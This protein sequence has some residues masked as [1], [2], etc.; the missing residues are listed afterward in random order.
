MGRSGFGVGRG[1]SLVL[2][3]LCSA[4][5]SIAG[6]SDGG[7]D[8]MGGAGGVAGLGGTGAVGGSAGASGIGGGG[9]GGAAGMVGGVGG[10]IGGVGGGGV[11]G[12]G[13]GGM[14]G[15]VGG[16]GVGGG[17]VG[18]MMAGTGGMGGTGGAI[19]RGEAP[20]MDSA[21]A[22]GPYT[23]DSY[24]SGFRAPMNFAG[25]TIWHPTGA[26]APFGA[27]AICPGFLSPESSIAEWG[28]FLAS[29]GIV[30]MTIETTTT[31]DQVA[32]RAPALMDALAIIK[33]ENSRSG[34][35]L[36]G[37]IDVD[38]L[39]LMGWSMGGGATW[40]NISE[41]PELKA[42][43]SLCGHYATYPGG[44]TFASSITVPIL[45]LAGSADNGIL[46]GGMS[47]PIYD[48]VPETTDKMLFEMA[49]GDHYVA[50][51]PG[52]NGGAFG[53]YGLS[54]Y[55]V[56]LEGDERYRQFLT[57]EGPN[58]SDFRTNL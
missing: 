6:C 11:G 58:A 42:A 9:A 12:G 10:M 3:A 37:Q 27:I 5:L 19:M 18:G 13:V 35:P 57:M 8:G 53:R 50:N 32:D 47:Q 40:I 52:G 44:S 23:V 14:T 46:G 49:G 48:L 24:T 7:G 34:S 56:F 22:D 38:R 51:T 43:V 31:G 39:G 17:G 41:H 20:T 2:A 4:L 1:R 55:K 15:G 36:T 54:W 26:D 33:E 25:G 29:H 21:T 16:G 28:P 45:M 30:V